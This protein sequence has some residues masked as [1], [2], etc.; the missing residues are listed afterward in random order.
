MTREEQ[1]QVASKMSANELMDKLV[2]YGGM[3]EGNTH[4][5]EVEALYN[6]IEV[7]KEEINNRIMG[8]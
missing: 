7:I 5:A 6:T 2:K 1:K 4:E 3:L 8:L